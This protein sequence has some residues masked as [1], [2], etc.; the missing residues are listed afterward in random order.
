M[1]LA[2]L[3]FL[4]LLS[5][6]VMTRAD[7]IPN[8]TYPLLVKRAN[9][10]D[11]VVPKGWVLEKKA[12]GDLNGDGKADIVLLLRQADPRNIVR[13]I[14]GQDVR[15]LD[16][17]PRILVGIFADKMSPGYTLAFVD[18]SLI[19]RHDSPTVDDPFDRI[20]ITDGKLLVSIHFW[21]SVGSYLTSNITFT[22][23]HQ[24]NCLRL[25]G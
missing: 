14:D 19:P 3:I 16:T 8:I 23:R 7:D 22:F 25:I 11:E 6:N 9:S 13:S 1:P 10:A 2:A 18:H 24:D 17:N 15:T 4:V 20:S 21:T 5:A 12:N